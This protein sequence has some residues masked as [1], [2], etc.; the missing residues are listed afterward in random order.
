MKKLFRRIVI[1]MCALFVLVGCSSSSSGTADVPAE[2]TGRTVYRIGMECDYAPNNWQE[3]TATDTNVEISN[4]S[5]FYAEGYDVQMALL[6][7]EYLDADIEIVK[8]AWGGLIESLNNG[9]IDMIIAG[10]GDTPERK[11]SINFSNTYSTHKTE[12][13]VVVRSDSEY[14]NATCLADFSGATIQGQVNTYYDGAI[15]Q[16]PGVNH[17]QAATDVPEM[18]YNVVNGLVDGIVVDDESALANAQDGMT[19]VTFANEADGFVVEMTGACVGLRLSDTELLDQVNAALATI[20]T[21]TR[22]A[23]MAHAMEIMPQ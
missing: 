21:D 12:Y 7:G 17:A 3:D 20:D 19:T 5:G 22:Y 10:M 9:Q 2:D 15:D 4:L 6:I 13:V 16:I 18:Y 14:A 23:M 1:V 8:L 11:Q